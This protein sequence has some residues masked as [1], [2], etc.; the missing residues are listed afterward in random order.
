MLTK[1][2]IIVRIRKNQSQK[3]FSKNVNIVERKLVWS[4][5]KQAYPNGDLLGAG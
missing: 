1:I 5:L 3:L 4:N 2:R